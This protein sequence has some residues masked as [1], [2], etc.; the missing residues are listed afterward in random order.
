MNKQI[1]IKYH[2]WNKKDCKKLNWV[3]RFENSGKTRILDNET[4]AFLLIN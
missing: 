1:D 4:R 2:K 3:T